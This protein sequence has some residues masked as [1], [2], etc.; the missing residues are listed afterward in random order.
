[1]VRKRAS[2]PQLN[3]LVVGTVSEI[4]DHGAFVTLDEYNGLRAYVPLGEVSH[5]WFK[6]IR[7]VLK[8][9]QK[10][11][12]KVI[13]A[14]SRK[15]IVDVSLRRVSDSEKRSKL[16]EWKRAQRAEKILE[17]AARALRRTLDEAY[18]EVG[19][20]LEDHYGEIFKGLEEAALK[21]VDALTAAGVS[22]R[23]ARAVANV[24]KQSIK[25]KKVRASALITLSCLKGGLKSVKDSLISWEEQ[26]KLPDNVSVKIYTIGAPKYRLDIESLDPMTCEKVLEEILKAITERAKRESCAVSVSVLKGKK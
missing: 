22:E 14:D 5:S 15:G 21:G 23:W 11:I 20:K 25:F 19:W 10:A 9:G 6:S 24:A 13:R 4:H 18:E 8:V 1:M 17:L 16:L 2:F 7:D 26:L 12:F 3:E